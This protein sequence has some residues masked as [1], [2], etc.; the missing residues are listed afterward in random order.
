MAI[1]PRSRGGQRQTDRKAIIIMSNFPPVFDGHNDVLLALYD[2]EPGKA[3]S[4]F[5]RSDIGHIDLPRAQAGGLGGGF[6]A[7]YEPA[8]RP[9]VPVEKPAATTP[10]TLADNDDDAPYSYAVPLAAPLEQ[11]YALAYA[12]AMIGT[13]YGLEA[14]AQGQARIVRTVA[15]IEACLTR[16]ALAMILHFEGADP[17]DADLLSLPVFYA[18]GLRSIGIVWSRP[19]AFGTGVPF[20]FPASPDIGPGLTPAGQRL[21]AAC[22]ELG[23]MLDLSHLNGAGFWDV[24]KL[25]NAPLVATHSGVHAICASPRNLTDEQL[26]AI[27]ASGGVVGI[28]FHTG[29]LRQDGRARRPTSLIEI[30]RH[31]DYVAE[32][33]G[34]DHVA[35]GSDFDGAPVPEDLKDVAGLPRL[36][37][38]L[39]SRGYDRAALAK[40]AYGNWLRVLRATWKSE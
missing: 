38:A 5:A 4:F 24:A 17:L 35:F 27:A 1:D 19:N 29:F 3:R 9:A 26:D 37:H 8:P 6:F 20:V 2:P 18:A 11:P 40:I 14:A 33:C 15:D 32:R 31:I 36:M 28:N 39:A 10:A 22:N 25:S 21:V 13:L 23:I 12:M 30:V 7:V 16:G 34:I